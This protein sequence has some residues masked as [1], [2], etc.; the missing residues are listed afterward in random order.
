MLGGA[1]R[2]ARRDWLFACLLAAGLVL[3]VLAQFAYRPALVYIDSDRYLRGLGDQDPLGYRGWLWPLQRVGGL[4]AVA[5]GQHILGLGM[6]VALYAVL[7]RRGLWRWTAALA[8]APILL[9]G[10]QLQAEQTIMPDVLFEAL[11]VAGLACALWRGRL[12]ARLACATGVLFGMAVDVRQVGEALLLPVLLLMVVCGPGWRRRL[13]CGALASAS[14]AVPVLGYMTARYT[15]TGHFA[16]TQRSGDMLYARAAAA[17]DCRTLRLP[18]DEQPLCPP[19]QTVAHLGIDGLLGDDNGPLSIYRPPQ[20]TTARAMA[21]RFAAAVVRQQPWAVI[22]SVDH[23]FL[24]LFALTR[25]GSPAVTPITR[26][27]FQ[28]SYPTYRPVITLQYVA[29]VQPGGSR[30]EVTRPLAEILRA[31]QLHGGY[32]SGPGLALAL[33]LGLAGSSAGG[34]LRGPHRSLAG[35]SMICT[36]AALAILL[37]SDAYEFSWR[38]QLPALVLLPL[39][40]ALGTATLA[41]RFRAERSAGAL[42]GPGRAASPVRLSP[43]HGRPPSWSLPPGLPSAGLTPQPGS[44]PVPRREASPR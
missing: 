10:Y 5:A 7:R 6:A 3:R 13:A 12:T 23:D 22:G 24:R 32:T 9:D 28:L 8:A 35:A 16:I 20:G 2:S 18:P 11:I 34:R 25:D 15:A 39:A 17:A 26:W 14:C 42:R 38:Y 31:Y 4:A 36:A 19:P 27:Q 29:H 44:G 30:P 43:A 21:G 41:A 33:I 1:A 37:A 40:G